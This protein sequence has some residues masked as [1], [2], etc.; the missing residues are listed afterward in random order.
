[1]A[2]DHYL[3]IIAGDVST[4]DGISIEVVKNDEVIIE[5]FR[6]DTDKT[7]TIN[8]FGNDIPLELMENAIEAFKKEIPWDFVDDE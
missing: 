6:D 2:L 7:R 8:T 3:I 4:R 1:M 5:I